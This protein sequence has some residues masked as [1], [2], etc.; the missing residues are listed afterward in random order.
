MKILLSNGQEAEYD[1]D[2][3]ELDAKLKEHGISRVLSPP[4]QISNAAA[5][6]IEGAKENVVAPLVTGIGK[7]IS[8]MALRRP[9][10]SYIPELT[11]EL[12][13]GKSLSEA[14]QGI[15]EKMGTDTAQ[16]VEEAGKTFGGWHQSEG[17]LQQTMEAGGHMLP[18][19]VPTLPAGGSGAANFLAKLFSYGFAPG[20][21]SE[22]AGQAAKGSTIPD[23]VPFVGGRDAEPWARFGAAVGASKPAGRLVTPL[24]VADRELLESNQVLNKA[25]VKQS[26]GQKTGRQWLQNIEGEHN[27]KL[28]EEQSKQFTLA[29]TAPLGKP[30]TDVTIGKGKY[31]PETI[32]EV[33]QNLDSVLNRNYIDPGV[34]TG[35]QRDEILTDLT[36]IAKKYPRHVSNILQTI[37]EQTGFKP[38]LNKSGQP[39]GFLPEEILH[40]T[41]FAGARQVPGINYNHLR[42]SLFRQARESASSNPT[43]AQSYRETARA[44][45]KAFDFSVAGG[46]SPDLGAVQ[47]ARQRY[48]DMSIVKGAR[49]HVDAGNR[50]KPNDLEREARA[51][52]GD[53]RYNAGDT[54]YQP[55]ASAA[56]KG[57][58]ELPGKIGMGSAV[59][60]MATGLVSALPGGIAG[61]QLGG[62]KGLLLG[63]FG[64]PTA[65][66]IG[67][68]MGQKGLATRPVQ[69]YLGNQVL[70][71]FPEDAGK[72]D[73]SAMLRAIQSQQPQQKEGP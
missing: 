34:M 50:L 10:L 72:R 64:L 45:D 63:L 27:P 60:S 43:L 23:W 13:Q 4:E 70:P 67:A 39:I 33:K 15:H 20:A 41:M 57:L 35:P 58:P 55:L 19:A 24:P 65:L 21:A 61:A 18:S 36:G 68:Y 2:L 38:N 49:S 56:Q 59:P 6:I 37:E 29:A 28:N 11:E 1:G 22:A 7:G 14:R 73:L 12:K 48:E 3:A 31:L 32:K 9:G 25:G 40:N 69:K 71:R 52:I 54:P 47:A 8:E 51:F 16:A 44:I 5:P 62:E 46:N 17:P 42:S 26:A 53:D 66:G 30:T